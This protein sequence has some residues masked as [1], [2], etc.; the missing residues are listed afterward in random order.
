MEKNNKG[1]RGGLDVRLGTL[2]V[3]IYSA[4]AILLSLTALVTLASAGKL[5]WDG[6]GHWATGAQ[7]LNVLNE[8]LVVLMLAELLHTVR[9]SIR[10][11]VLVTEPFLVVGLIACIRRI[12]VVTLEASTL[13]KDGAWTTGAAPGIFRASMLELGLLALLVIALVSSIV[14]LRRN[15]PASQGPAQAE[16]G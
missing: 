1:L 14:L 8:L 5:L 3:V 6:L 13:Y 12:L 15:P 16:A 7:T 2:E 4:L 11:H 9:I 10:S